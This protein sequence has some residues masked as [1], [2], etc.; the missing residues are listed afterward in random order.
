[1]T[2][3]KN[4]WQL[5]NMAK[6][7]LVG[8]YSEA[9]LL[10]TAYGVFSIAHIAITTIL[11]SL[12]SDFQETM[13][14]V[15]TFEMVPYGYLISIGVSLAFNLLLSLLTV[16][17]SLFYLNMACKA[18]FSV[19]DLFIAFRENPFKFLTIAL[20]QV[21]VQFFFAL[22]GYACDYFYMVQPTDQW[23][24]LGYI[25]QLAGQIVAYPI[26]LAL[27]QSYRLLLDYPTLSTWQVLRRSCRLMKGH[28]AR[29][30]WLMITFVP[31]EFA[32]IFTCGIGYLWLS[33]YMNMT[34]THF[35]LDLMDAEKQAAS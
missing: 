18:P 27:S 26:I 13:M 34:Y 2:Q 17:V 6:N 23:M 35:Y 11:M 30:F 21:L 33:P 24:M 1:M 12:G 31:L 22:P 19:K 3:H 25:C 16:G 15:I 20:I 10:T 8:N 32:A 7:S 4:N 5:K 28:K 9:I 29:L 14:N